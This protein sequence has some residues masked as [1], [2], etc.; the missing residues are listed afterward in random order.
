MEKAKMI[1]QSRIIGE[2][3]WTKS[4]ISE[5]LP[6][7]I[8]KKNPHYSS[9]AQMK[10]WEE[11]TVEDIMK[12]KEFQ[13]AM[14]KATRRKKSANMAVDTKRNNMFRS[15]EDFIESI[16][17][18]VLSDDELRSRTLQK[19]QQWYDSHPYYLEDYLDEEIVENAYEA[20][21]DTLVRWIVNYIRHNLI[22]YDYFLYKIHG[23]IGSIGM[24]SEI[25][26]GV[27]RKIAVAYPKYKEECERQILFI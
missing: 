24:Y 9:A 23:K 27:L 18:E 4:L 13:Q 19:K 26:A 3:G 16:K 10:L 12:T 11:K 1:T 8:L 20:D 2:Y 17:I 15:I 21:E 6:E 22:D 5:F 7:P 14:E 25:K